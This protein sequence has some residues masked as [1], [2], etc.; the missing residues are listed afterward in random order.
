MDLINTYDYHWP[1]ADCTVTTKTL[2]TCISKD[3]ISSQKYIGFPYSK[4]LDA[5]VTWQ[6]ENREDYKTFSSNAQ[7]KPNPENTDASSQTSTNTES[8]STSSNTDPVKSS[9]IEDKP[10]QNEENSSNYIID[11]KLYLLFALILL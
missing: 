2:L 10:T 11:A 3:T 6:N 4:S 8:S 7:D 1:G 5:S 9:P